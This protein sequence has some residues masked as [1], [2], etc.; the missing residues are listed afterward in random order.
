MN[1][2][3]YSSFEGVSSNHR[4]VTKILLN[5]CRNRGT[6]KQTTHYDWSLLNNT[7]NSD[8]I[9]LRNKFDP[10]QEIIETLTLN[11]SAHMEAATECI[12]TKL[13]G[14]HQVQ[15][16]GN[17]KTASLYNKRNPTNAQKFKKAQSELTHTKKNK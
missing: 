10:L 13:K 16:Q 9:T 15:K 7:D 6:N 12:P 1:H 4:I 17:M 5:L 2:E 11:I 14:K 3:A 8:T